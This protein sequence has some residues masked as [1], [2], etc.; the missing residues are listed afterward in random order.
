MKKTIFALFTI[1]AL[2][3]CGTKSTE[4]K[5]DSIVEVDSTIVDSL[6][7]NSTDSVLD[8]MAVEVK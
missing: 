1:V 6:T 3:S 8:T 2:V 4:T 5:S 7:K